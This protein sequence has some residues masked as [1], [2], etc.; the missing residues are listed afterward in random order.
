MARGEYGVGN[1]VRESRERGPCRGTTSYG[2]S[3]SRSCSPPRPTFSVCTNATGLPR[4][5]LTRLLCDAGHLRA[6]EDAAGGVG[7]APVHGEGTSATTVSGCIRPEVSC[8]T[9]PPTSSG[10][11]KWFIF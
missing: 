8:D 11:L 4:L 3:H 7:V 6:A 10:R 5:P 1:V 2:R 9:R